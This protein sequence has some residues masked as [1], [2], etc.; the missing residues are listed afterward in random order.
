MSKRELI[1]KLDYEGTD[2]GDDA[3][4]R[5]CR[6]LVGGRVKSAHVVI[7]TEHSKAGQAAA[8]TMTA[9][10]ASTPRI[11]GDSL[12][13][14]IRRMS[15][16]EQKQVDEMVLRAIDMAGSRPAAELSS[17]SRTSVAASMAE[18]ARMAV[19]AKSPED[20]RAIIE[21]P[22]ELPSR[23][24]AAKYVL[25]HPSD[26]HIYWATDEAG[27]LRSFVGVPTTPVHSDSRSAA[28]ITPA[29][30]PEPEGWVIAQIKRA[31]ICIGREPTRAEAAAWREWVT[32]DRLRNETV[33]KYL[34]HRVPELEG[35]A[36][37]TT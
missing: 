20:L 35:R 16:E 2:M 26:D 22:D 17:L 37:T 4:E 6:S 5:L 23:R 11:T 12:I 10:R 7:D 30:L 3:R 31:G 21:S 1:L 32:T 36:P 27:N 13:E 34:S 25:E 24:A 18:S 28:P 29:V 19:Q 33:K 8:V 15:P 9:P 14:K